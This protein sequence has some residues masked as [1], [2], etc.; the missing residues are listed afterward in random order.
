VD[1][2]KSEMSK[3]IKDKKEEAERNKA[4]FTTSG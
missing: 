1:D 4:I 3:I 2:L